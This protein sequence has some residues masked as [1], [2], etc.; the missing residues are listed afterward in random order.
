LW[1]RLTQDLTKLF[2]TEV[3]FDY[4]AAHSE[5]MQAQES[6]E[7]LDKGNDTSQSCV[8]PSTA[9]SLCW[10]VLAQELQASLKQKTDPLLAQS[11]RYQPVDELL[12]LVKKQ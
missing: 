12:G 3:V 4:E 1:C 2:V 9:H 8:C 5:V 11:W 10:L 7:A 6:S